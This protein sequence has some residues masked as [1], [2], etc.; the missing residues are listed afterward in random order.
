MAYWGKRVILDIVI[1]VVTG[2]PGFYSRREI[3]EAYAKA[4]KRDVEKI[5]YYLSFAF[6]NSLLF[7]SKFIICG[8]QDH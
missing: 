5:D 2:Q 8:K 3:V 7:Y 4:S 6:I 1:H